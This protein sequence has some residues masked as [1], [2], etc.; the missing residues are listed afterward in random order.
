MFLL[1]NG[2]EYLVMKDV[3]KDEVYSAFFALIFTGKTGL[4]QFQVSKTSTK[5][6]RKDDLPLVKVD[7]VREHLNR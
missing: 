6:W 3:E 1:V 5:V 4:Q 7:Q 2:A